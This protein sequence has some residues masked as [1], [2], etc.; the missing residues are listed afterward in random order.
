[1]LDNP[2]QVPSRNGQCCGPH[3]SPNWPAV[4][5][6]YDRREAANI[7]EAAQIANRSKR[8][9]RDWAMLHLLGRKI[10]GRWMVSR[11]ALAMFLDGDRDALKLY[12]GGDRNSRVVAGYF[13]RLDV[14]LPRPRAA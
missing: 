13:E 10:A 1:M 2:W 4:L 9:V 11:V 8:T 14:P 3:T 12:L 5:L 6:P 7:A